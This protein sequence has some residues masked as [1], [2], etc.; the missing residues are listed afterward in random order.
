MSY[1]SALSAPGGAAH[2][3]KCDETSGTT[4]TDSVGSSNG[5]ITSGTTLG[6]TGLVPDGGTA[7]QVSSTKILTT[8]SAANSGV[9]TLVFA[10]KWTS[11]TSGTLF[12]N[13]STVNR[14][15]LDR[16]NST[17]LS[18]RILGTTHSLPSMDANFNDG[19]KRLFVIVLDGTNC[20]VYVIT[21]TGVVTSGSFAQ[22]G[23][24]STI[25]GG[26]IQWS[27]QASA[28]AAPGVIDDIYMSTNAFTSGQ[29]TTLA[30]E[31]PG[32]TAYNGDAAPTVTI[33]SSATGISGKVVG[34]TR[35]ITIGA[36]AA[37]NLGL[38]GTATKTIT[39]T[40]S[41]TGVRGKVA[42]VAATLTIAAAAAGVV[43][44][45][46]SGNAG[47]IV[48]VSATAAANLGIHAT[49]TRALTLTPT[50][51]GAHG[52]AG[53]V[54]AT[55]AISGSADGAVSSAPRTHLAWDG[56]LGI[57]FSSSG[58]E[59]DPAYVAPP[60]PL[61]TRV[62]VAQ[63]VDSVAQNGVQF[64]PSVRTAEDGYAPYRIVVGGTDVTYFRDVQTPMPTYGLVSPLRYGSGQITF[65]QVHAA[66]ER[67]G[68]GELSWLRKFAPVKIQRVD[69]GGTVLATDYVGFISDYQHQGRTLTCTL[70]GE[71]TGL[72]AMVD[73]PVPVFANVHDIGSLVQQTIRT[74]LRL[75]TVNT[76][77][78]GIRLQDT[79]GMP[80]LDFL[81]ETLAKSTTKD[82][83]QWTVRPTATGRYKME[84]KDTATVRASVYIDGFRVVE[85][86]HRD[87]TEEPNRVYAQGVGPDG[88]R[89]RFAI[90][91]GLAQAGDI[92]FPG[93][94]SPGDAGT[95]VTQMLW[96][97]FTMG[98]LDDSPND[99]TWT[100]AADDPITGAIKDLQADAGLSQTGVVNA[101]TWRALFNPDVT[102]Y[103]LKRSQIVP[104]AQ[105]SF[106]KFYLTDA[107]GNIIGRNP[108]YLRNKP[109]VDVSVDMG[110]GFTRHQMAQWAR[111]ELA[112]DNAA[113]WV[114]TVTVT[115]GAVINGTHN[116]GDP[117]DTSDVLDARAIH[118]GDN[119]W[120][121]N[122][123]DG[124]L[125]HVSG[126]NVSA[127]SVEFAVDTR[128]RDTMKVWQV[129]SR[130][131]ESRKSPARQWIA[132]NRRSHVRDDTGA[133]Y[134][135]ATFGKVPRTFC[136][137]DT[138]TVIPTPAGRSGI[139]QTIDIQTTDSQAKFIL[140]AWGRQVDGDWVDRK[141]GDP[142]FGDLADTTFYDRV[143]AD[144]KTWQDA[145][146]LVEVWG[147]N[148][149]PG[150]YWP[151]QHTNAAG[152]VTDA[153]IT[154][155]FRFTA[156]APY[157]CQHEPVL[158]IAIRPDRNCWVEGGRVLELLLDDGA[159]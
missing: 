109:Y 54:T 55:L 86:L 93:T 130:N 52:K 155:Q 15:N 49:S 117:L 78:T 61:A 69:S 122:W 136:P 51:A 30:G 46:G 60:V 140:S 135:G 113:N 139:L 11:G 77:T 107:T 129:I 62:I 36:T 32:S 89:N 33:A 31:F 90:Y 58:G 13:T 96:R 91:P 119:L 116:P 27:Q 63:A 72:A 23:T 1:D 66:Y 111:Q 88:L 74:S 38:K 115:M 158:W 28:T 59:F 157:L 71:A 41:G 17:D 121:P 48:T 29:V 3:Y 97:L 144:T 118:P 25:M 99:E 73:R 67:P 114:G 110:T 154:G 125:V 79:G 105:R 10:W 127:T 65:P 37:A 98:Y 9:K 126:V 42:T 64:T 82:G 87:F 57:A 56:G 134:D 138:T 44:H 18:F 108:A 53:A 150:G 40:P 8:L 159:G 7:A 22:T 35:T 47:R 24:L 76:P 141:L 14:S 2:R 153:P 21:S 142:V 131:R 147:Q 128:A 80:V 83:K 68:Y 70:G 133:F 50:A 145:R 34:A 149:Q 152:T 148:T 143:Q 132:Q 102:G 123:D 4:L 5:T 39:V 120:L 12:G 20:T 84:Q 19:L 6:V 81:T 103:S 26:N 16:S 137:A 100:T 112:D 94:L 156:G 85:D 146:G 151:R 101:A 104:A 45:G 124:T 75:A 95:A 106:T 43:V 92:G